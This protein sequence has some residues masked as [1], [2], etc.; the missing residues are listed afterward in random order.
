MCKVEPVQQYR[1]GKKMN[2]KMGINKYSNNIL[3]YNVV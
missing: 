2:N 3:W 1:F